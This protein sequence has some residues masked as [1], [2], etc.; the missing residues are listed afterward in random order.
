MATNWNAILANINNASDILAI[1][2]KILGLLDGK[3]D[4]TRID[5]I[6]ENFESLQLDVNTALNSLNEALKIANSA[7]FTVESIDDLSNLTLLWQGRTVYVKSYHAGIIGTVI[8]YKGGGTFVYDSTRKNENDGGVCINGWVRQLE[9]RVLNPYMFGAYGDLQFTSNEVLAYQSGHDDT[10]AFKKML[11]MNKYVIFTNISKAVSSN[12]Y[13][14]YTFELPHAAYYIKDTL[15]VRAFT[16]IEGNNSTIFF[17]PDEP[18]DLFKTPRSEMQAA[19]QVSTGWNTQTIPMC[20]FSNLIIVG[21]VTRTSTTHAQ[22]CF[23]AGNAY[24][25][26]WSN[27]LIERFQNGI[28]IYPLDTSAWTGGER[29]GNFYENVLDN[30]TINECIQHFYNAGNVTQATNLTLAGGYVVGKDFVNKFD[31]FLI[32]Y[33][34]GFSCNGFNIAPADDQ[35]LAKA[36]I[37]DA[38]LGSYYSGGYTEWFNTFFELDIPARMGGFKYDASHTF[39]YPE[40]I[41]FKIKDGV[42]SKYIYETSTRTIPKKFENGR[43]YNNY[44]NQTGIGFGANSEL[45]TNFF[46]Y[47]PQYDFKYG[48]Y[49]VSGLSNDLVYD[50]KRF[51]EVDT[52][53]TTRYGIRLINPTASSIDL[54]LPLNN[55]E[56]MAKVVFLYRPIKNFDHSNFKS[57]VLGFNGTNARISTGEIMVDYGNDWKLAVLEVTSEQTRTGNIVITLP[58]DS[59]VEI[60]HVG[61]YANGFPLM[62]SYKEYQ[63]LINNPLVENA[64]DVDSGGTFAKGDILR[65]IANVNGGAIVGTVS[66]YAVLTQGMY[67]SRHVGVGSVALPSGINTINVAGTDTLKRLGIGAYVEVQQS[68][69][70]NKYLVVG[71]NFSNGEFDFTLKFSGETTITV[72]SVLFDTNY[73][74]Q[75]NYRLLQYY[76]NNYISRKLSYAGVSIPAN[77]IVSRNIVLSGV[78]MADT[79]LAAT[80]P[81]LGTSSRIW[82]EVTALDQIT[83]YHQNLTGSNITT[84]DDMIIN[85]KIV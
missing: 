76:Q 9:N 12:K 45:I 23:D 47:V 22:K 54:T 30:V 62:P 37:H 18:I 43:L 2:R 68:S 58:A 81:S 32:N 10:E 5:E 34:A 71:R 38:C 28:S 73:M 52:G 51:E 7:I 79:A 11:N 35:Q 55:Q 15:P 59:Q 50:V 63:P 21:N 49:G 1:L 70:K 40:H 61:A 8:P 14:T 4:L 85:I 75:P 48:L 44:L 77:S 25:W 39:K 33:G 82:A 84:P 26:R 16:K 20:E 53:F 56:V 57:N 6:I 41:M 83:V 64:V 36:L 13:S 27:I 60:E 66:D 46:K 72:G 29:I 31:Y 69:I 67:S 78:T 17:D 80:S 74:Q 3:V 65:A 24:K 19:Y 42:F